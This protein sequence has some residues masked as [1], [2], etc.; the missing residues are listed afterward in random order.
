M[1]VVKRYDS[2]AMAEL[3]RTLLSDNGIEAV[4]LNENA[5][6]YIAPLAGGL[7]SVELAVA[8]EDEQRASEILR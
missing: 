1:K 7:V 5:T 4:V 2:S 3:D 8:D 6:C